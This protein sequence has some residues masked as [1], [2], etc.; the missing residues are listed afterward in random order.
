MASPR[1]NGFH[2]VNVTLFASATLCLV[3]AAQPSVARADPLGA[4]GGTIYRL[5]P[6]SSYQN[7]CF[8]PLIVNPLVVCWQGVRNK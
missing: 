1:R 8:P 6:G 4:G 2:A 7:G 5:G 3:L